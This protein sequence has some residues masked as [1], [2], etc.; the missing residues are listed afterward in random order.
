MRN[1]SAHLSLGV[2]GV[3]SSARTVDY[4]LIFKGEADNAQKQPFCPIVGKHCPG[5]AASVGSRVK[6]LT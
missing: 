2:V 4:I 3:N 6:R 5:Y 1:T